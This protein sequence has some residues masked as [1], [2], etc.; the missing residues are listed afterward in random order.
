MVSK[1]SGKKFFFAQTQ[2]NILLK[3]RL[4]IRVRNFAAPNE[5]LTIKKQ[6]FILIQKS[7]PIETLWCKNHQN[8]SYRKSHT[9]APLRQNLVLF[10]S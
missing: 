10:V 8:P 3:I 9:W 5:P 2:K 4:S 6:T 1:A 7:P